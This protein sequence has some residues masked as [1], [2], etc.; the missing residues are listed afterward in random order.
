M[1]S[2]VFTCS[3]TKFHV[4]L[5][6]MPTNSWKCIRWIQP[7][8][9]R[10]GDQPHS[11]P[12]TPITTLPNFSP[13]VQP[14]SIP[15]EHLLMIRP[16]PSVRVRCYFPPVGKLVDPADVALQQCND[17][18]PRHRPNCSDTNPELCMPS[19][20]PQP[21]L[22]RGQLKPLTIPTRPASPHGQWSPLVAMGQRGE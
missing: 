15:T 2:L 4:S 9:H 10:Q 1:A 13:R 3:V 16:D 18:L 20:H 6:S 21:V 12:R 22:V 8:L 11:P 14:L 17:S 5:N 7:N 19:P